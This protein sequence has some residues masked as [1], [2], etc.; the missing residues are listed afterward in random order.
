MVTGVDGKKLPIT[1]G[2]PFK[3]GGR[4]YLCG[5]FDQNPDRFFDGELA[6]LGLFSTALTEEKVL[7]SAFSTKLERKYR[8]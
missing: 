7:I 3:P 4:I 5:R 6:H 2:D 1:G 8:V